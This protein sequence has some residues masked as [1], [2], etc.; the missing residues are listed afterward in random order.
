MYY[1]V[2]NKNNICIVS[3]I[4]G[5]QGMQ[6]PGNKMTAFNQPQLSQLRAQIMAYKFLARNQ[7][8]P[9]NLRAAVEGKRP[10][11]TGIPRP[12]GLRLIL[13]YL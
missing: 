11:F 12:Q 5:H 3:I 13:I 10:P 6:Q 8:I 2:Y 7:S 4:A 9:E 1:L